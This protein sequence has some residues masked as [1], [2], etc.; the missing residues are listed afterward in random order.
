MKIGIFGKMAYLNHQ[1]KTGFKPRLFVAEYF[2]KPAFHLITCRGFFVHPLR[3]DNAEPRKRNRD[4]INRRPCAE[5]P[6]RK[7]QKLTA[8]LL[9]ASQYADKFPAFFQSL[10]PAEP[11]LFHCKIICQRLLRSGVCG[12]CVCGR[13]VL[14]VRRAFSFSSGIRAF[15]DVFFWKAAKYVYS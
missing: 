15:C 12:L 10:F 11:K 4:V 5:F 13:R 9:P 1:I 3:Y 8:Q 6:V 14:F 7:S 2:P